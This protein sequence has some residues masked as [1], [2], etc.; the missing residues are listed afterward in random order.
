M[1][2]SRYVYEIDCNFKIGDKVV[3]KER[4][5]EIVA[6]EFKINGKEN[7]D[8]KV[9]YFMIDENNHLETVYENKNIKE[10]I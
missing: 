2:K 5:Y 4:K 6:I 3:Y 1:K 7:N 10:I 9:L 8:V